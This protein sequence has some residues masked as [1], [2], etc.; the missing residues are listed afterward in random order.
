MMRR[1][2]LAAS[3]A[4]IAATVACGG[5]QS[6]N[7]SSPGPT[8]AAALALHF[9]TLAGA[10]QASSPGDIRLIWYQDIASILARGV[11]PSGLSAF[12]EG[13]PA[14]FSAVTEADQFPDTVHGKVADSSY[15][16]AAWAPSRQP[17]AF[18]D[19]RVRFWPAGVGKTDTTTTFVQVY[20]DTLGGSRVDSTGGAALQAVSSRGS[21]MIT[22]L[23]HLTVPT[24]PCS[25]IS[26]EWVVGGGTA[27][28]V[29][30]PAVQV[31]GA[32]LTH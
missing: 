7:N 19:V 11:S 28:L 9:D 8:T 20:G 5:D 3:V 21:C 13:G 14:V 32:H 15:R 16:L 31:S 24:N 30:D 17:M 10:L 12:V 1:V 29:I 26:V 27:L 2:L 18:I 23:A 6:T 25:R 22:P 4:A